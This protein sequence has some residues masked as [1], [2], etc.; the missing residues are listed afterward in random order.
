MQY[1]RQGLFVTIVLLAVFSPD[2]TRIVTASE[3]G[4]ARVWD[5]RY[6]TGRVDWAKSH[7]MS[8][9]ATVCRDKLRTESVRR[10]TRGDT[11]A[12][13]IFRGREGEDACSP[14]LR[15]ER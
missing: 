7:S 9:E 5:V 11:A 10:I 14:F 3:D 4:T 8:M 1:Y 6:L 2:S 13:S 15:S 12:A